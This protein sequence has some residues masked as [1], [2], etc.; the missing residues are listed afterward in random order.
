MT[1]VRQQLGPALAVARQRRLGLDRA[2]QP[3]LG[4]ADALGLARAPSHRDLGQQQHGL[5]RERLALDRALEREL[6]LAQIDRLGLQQQRLAQAGPRPRREGL[7]LGQRLQLAQ[8]DRWIP[9]A[10]LDARARDLDLDAAGQQLLGATDPR[11]GLLEAPLFDQGERLDVGHARPLLR[12]GCEIGQRRHHVALDEADPGV[13]DGQLVVRE[14]G[15]V[16]P[17]ARRRGV[18]GLERG[19]DRESHR[20][21]IPARDALAGLGQARHALGDLAGAHV[22]DRPRQQGVVAIAVRQ[23]LADLEQLVGHARDARGLTPEHGVEQRLVGREPEVAAREFPSALELAQGLVGLAQLQLQPR[24]HPAQR[25]VAGVVVERGVDLGEHCTQAVTIVGACRDGELGREP[26]RLD[27][28]EGVVDAAQLRQRRRRGVAVAVAEA[29]QRLRDLGCDHVGRRG[30]GRVGEIAAFAELEPQVRPQQRAFG[31]GGGVLGVAHQRRVEQVAGEPQVGCVTAARVGPRV[32]QRGRARAAIGEQ[33]ERHARGEQRGAER[34][35]LRRAL[36]HASPL[37]RVDLGDQIT[38]ARDA[39]SARERSIRAP[40]IHDRTSVRSD[41]RPD[42]SSRRQN[43]AACS[44]REAADGNSSSA[45]AERIPRI[46]AAGVAPQA[47]ARP[48]VEAPARLRAVEPA[49]RAAVAVQARRRGRRAP[50]R[51]RELAHEHRLDLVEPADRIGRAPQRGRDRHV[52][53][54]REHVGGHVDRTEELGLHVAVGIE[55]RVPPL[56]RDLT[57]VL[58]QRGGHGLAI[59]CRPRQR[60]AVDLRQH[61]ELAAAGIE[62]GDE[63]IAV[64]L[65]LDACDLVIASQQRARELGAVVVAREQRGARGV[66]HQLDFGDLERARGR[67]LGV[68]VAR[69]QRRSGEGRSG[70]P[71]RTADR[72]GENQHRR[73]P[74][75]DESAQHLRRA[76]TRGLVPSAHR[77]GLIA[78]GRQRITAIAGRAPGRRRPGRGLALARLRAVLVVRADVVGLAV[79]QQ[80]RQPRVIVLDELAEDTE[81]LTAAA[82]LVDQ[83]ELALVE[84]PQLIDHGRLDHGA[85]VRV[86]PDLRARGC[87]AGG[88]VEVEPRELVVDDDQLLGEVLVGR[89]ELLLRVGRQELCRA[90]D[91]AP[92]QR[93]VVVGGGVAQLGLHAVAGDAAAEHAHGHEQGEHDATADGGGHRAHATAGRGAPASFRRFRVQ[94]TGG[95]TRR[96]RTM[97]SMPA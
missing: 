38:A 68:M 13:I 79:G 81:P 50:D 61:R 1:G 33:L 87:D 32:V 94:A 42:P 14:I 3:R 73:R 45:C 95:A 77:H 29:Q 91:V 6:G 54:G 60:G 27:A 82:P 9:A 47:H 65:Q 93:L 84:L 18:A 7:L 57:P 43:A 19:L 15:V 8:R 55:Q 62:L 44:E 92:A 72:G 21:A 41:C 37:L 49:A 40:A 16:E 74:A 39:Q 53:R 25:G 89:E 96:P 70:D 52:G 12:Q 85:V 64:E 51:G 67:G 28:G 34:H 90:I 66:L 11:L 69:G 2:R 24:P 10:Q 71:A 75:G 48:A 30:H 5:G 20:Q 17:R 97:R 86:P 80:A 63:S 36:D 26:G 76:P 78:L 35:E 83:H 58:A 59:R 23:R 88:L 4:V 46:L 56:R 31:C 22:H